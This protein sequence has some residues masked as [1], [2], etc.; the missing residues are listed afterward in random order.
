MAKLNLKLQDQFGEA[1]YLQCFSGSNL[2]RIPR[3]TLLSLAKCYSDVF[4]ESWGEDWTVESALEEIMH[5]VHCNPAYLPVMTILFNEDRVIGFSW[6]YL[7]DSDALTNDSAPFS[8]S[9]VKRHESVAVARYWMERVGNKSKL[10]SIRELGVIKEY[11]QDKTPY[12]M[13]PIFDKASSLDCNVAFLRT[14]VTSTAFKWCLGVGLL[15]L[16]YFM[17]DDLL[18]MRGSV[19]YALA[20]FSGSIDATIR[21]KTQV[22]IIGNIKRYLCD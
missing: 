3:S 14:K 15:P 17:V 5:C 6:A 13:V 8:A 1:F 22:E 7:L 19:K 11:R 4:N 2:K 12:L 20:M 10:V 21:R 16:Q 18:L 9:A